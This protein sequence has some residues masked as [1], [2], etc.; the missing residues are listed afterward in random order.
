MLLTSRSR[1][2]LKEIMDSEHPLRVKDLAGEFQ[3]SERTI[4]YDIN[5]IRIWLKE[6]GAHLSSKPNKGI[7]FDEDILLRN[8]LRGMLVEN[9]KSNVFFNQFERSEN[10]VLDLLLAD[11]YLSVQFLGDKLGVSRNTILAD[12]LKAEDFLHSWNL[13]AERKSATGIKILGSEFQRRLACEY[14]LQARLSSKE[15]FKVVQAV[16]KGKVQDNQLSEKLL[17]PLQEMNSVLHVVK[18]LNIRLCEESEIY[19]TDQIIIGSLIRLCLVINRIRHGHELDIEVDRHTLEGPRQSK[20]FTICLDVLNDLGEELRMKF[21]LKEVFYTSLQVLSGSL[22]LHQDELSDYRGT[23]DPVIVAQKIIVRASES[24]KIPFIEDAELMDN[25]LVHLSDKLAKFRYGV[26]EPNPLVNQ[27][28]RSYPQMFEHIK[29]V[30]FNVLQEFG[31]Y[32]TEP[33]IAYIVLHFQAAYERR[34]AVV[35]YKIFVVCGTGRGTARLVRTL[36]E[37]ELKNIQV[38]G[39]CSIMEV[40]KALKSQTVDFVTSVL[41]IDLPIPV[42]VINP[43]PTKQDFEAILKLTE[44]LGRKIT[45]PIFEHKVRKNT[46]HLRPDLTLNLPTE[47]IPHIERI[48]RDILIQGFIISQV[49]IN[50]FKAYL[51]EQAAAGLML[52]ISLMVHRFVFSTPFEDNTSI[53]SLEPDYMTSLRS[54]LVQIFEEYDLIVPT[55]EL[56][57]IL[58]YFNGPEWGKEIDS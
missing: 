13:R 16:M 54:K 14:L 27:I 48:S 51:T 52:H 47:Q 21:P 3:V 17:L 29:I 2:I 4:K 19:F 44:Q 49:I 30:C 58:R 12:M 15:M 6:H 7:W 40:E 50:E 22:S 46:M 20:A 41:P 18:E 35:K 55:G 26:I 43:I 39:I 28:K 37:N 5:A 10:L 23:P 1:E 42:V 53:D 57:A 31:I 8:K 36:L 38:V 25:L 9:D 32:F 34:D 56:N 24:L 11:Q 33:D 45:E